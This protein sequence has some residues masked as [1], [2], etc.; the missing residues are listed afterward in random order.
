MTTVH[1]RITVPTI[2]GV[3]VGAKGK[4]R[5]TP[6]LR[7][8][9]DPNT[10]VLPKG[11]DVDLVSGEARVNVAPTSGNWCWKVEEGLYRV[12]VPNGTTRYVSIPDSEAV[13]NY[14]DLPDLDPATLEPTATPAAVW[15]V[16]LSQVDERVT[17]LENA[18]PAH[19]HD[20]KDALDLVSGTNTGDEPDASDTVKGVVELAT[21]AETTTGTD[22]TRAATPAGVKAALD[23][24]T[25]S[26]MSTYVAQ[27]GLDDSATALAADTGSALGSTLGHQVYTVPTFTPDAAVLA[28]YA[29][30]HAAYDALMALAPEY[31]TKDTLGLNAQGAPLVRYTFTE[32]VAAGVGAS[33]KTRVGI[34][35]GT[36][37]NEKASVVAILRLMESLVDAGTE[38]ARVMRANTVIEVIPVV[39]PTGYDAETR[40]NGQD[41]NINRNFTTNWSALEEGAGAAAASELETQIVEAWLTAG[42][43]DS[44]FDAHTHLAQLETDHVVTWTRVPDNTP[45]DVAALR[46]Y[47]ESISAL[48]LTWPQRWAA[49]PE[50]VNFGR[51]NGSYLIYGSCVDQARAAGIPLCMTLECSDSLRY[52]RTWDG[53]L[54][55]TTGAEIFG[56]VIIRTAL[57]LSAADDED[58]GWLDVTA[59]AMDAT[60]WES[61]A[62]N[63]QLLIRR[64]GT[65]VS[66]TVRASAKTTGTLSSAKTLITLP[67]G[68]RTPT[69][70][71]TYGIVYYKSIGT[72]IGVCYT[73]GNGIAKLQVAF[74]SASSYVV[75][76]TITGS[77]SWETNDAF[78]V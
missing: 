59:T 28:S 32:P 67:V 37:G 47:T 74:N 55:C 49:F 58:T 10:V 51:A 14:I 18:P 61:L 57:D 46:V 31:V 17:T 69:D 53:P 36:H 4:L 78:P 19:T 30:V 7:R 41:V 29:G 35:S 39:N 38:R 6:T 24:K 40:N 73:N 8:N 62:S 76:E 9:V 45:R 42:D 60:N 3:N 21:T 56:N 34:V 43:F 75:G 13:I 50:G 54:A 72:A 2:T 63:Q 23:A 26:D 1:I 48:S 16:E 70:Y 27:T 12:G 77:A 20:N 15:D 71:R 5:W 44:F 65:R 68:Y 52:D 11:F 25:V 66:L 33:P 22:T 64:V